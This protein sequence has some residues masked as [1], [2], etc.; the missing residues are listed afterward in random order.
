MSPRSA[1]WRRCCPSASALSRNYWLRCKSR[2]VDLAS[3]AMGGSGRHD[4]RSGT[5]HDSRNRGSCLRGSSDRL[6]RWRTSRALL[7]GP[8]ALL[9]GIGD[10]RLQ[11]VWVGGAPSVAA[12]RGTSYAGAGAAPAASPSAHHLDSH[13]VTAMLS[14]SVFLASPT[15]TEDPTADVMCPS[16]VTT[17]GSPL[18]FASPS[19]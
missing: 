15:P 3:R 12:R 7:Q 11:A 13:R 1:Y 8:G 16:R 2:R 19:T 18:T 17:A 6:P 5:P 9:H 10:V 4:S 14:G